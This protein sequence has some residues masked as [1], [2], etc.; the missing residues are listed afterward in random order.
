MDQELLRHVLNDRAAH[1]PAFTPDLDQLIRQGRSSSRRRTALLTMMAGA[2]VVAAFALG[3]AIGQGGK[4]AGTVSITPITPSPTGR[5]YTG[6]S[7][8]YCEPPSI[9]QCEAA[10]PMSPTPDIPG[11]AKQLYA[12]PI[13]IPITHTG[14]YSYSVPA[15]GIR[16]AF[17]SFASSYKVVPNTATLGNVHIFPPDTPGN[18]TSVDISFDVTAFSGTPALL[19]ESV[20][21]ENLG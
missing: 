21:V 15:S 9:A 2:V 12:L 4:S 1:A 13:R 11:Y 6:P 14:H 8:V 10:H 18:P 3:L 7:P 20:E 5:V 17:N 16:Q 19:I